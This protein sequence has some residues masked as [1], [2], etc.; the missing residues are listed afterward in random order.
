MILSSLCI[1][2]FVNIKHLL[3][4]NN[5]SH[6]KV[7]FLIYTRFT[8]AVLCLPFIWHGHFPF[9]YLRSICVIE[10][11]ASSYSHNIV[12]YC[13]VSKATIYTLDVTVLSCFCNYWYGCFHTCHFVFVIY[14]SYKI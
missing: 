12:G 10:F 6:L 2:I 14:R 1:G 5:I 11:K 13:F 4:L 3:S 7:Y 9:F 8:P